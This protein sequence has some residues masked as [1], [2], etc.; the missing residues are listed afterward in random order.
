MLGRHSDPPGGRDAAHTDHAT[1]DV[2]AVHV[3]RV[4]HALHAI[5][6]D[7]ALPAGATRH[8]DGVMPCQNTWTHAGVNMGMH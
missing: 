1:R 8:A 5:H 3:T 7:H 2:H 4:G 6:I